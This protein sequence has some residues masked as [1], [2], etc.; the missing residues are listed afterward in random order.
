MAENLEA[1]PQCIFLFDMA[2]CRSH[3]FFRYLSTHPEVLPLWHPFLPAFLFGPERFTLRTKNSF[4]G[5]WIPPSEG[6]STYSDMTKIFLDVVKNT[7]EKGK[8]LV[9]NEHCQMVLKQDVTLS[10]IRGSWD[11]QIPRSNPTVIPDQIFATLRPIFII[12]NPV[13]SV[14]SSYISFSETSQIRTGDEDWTTIIDLRLPRMIFDYFKAN[15]GATPIVIDGDDIVWRTSEVGKKLCQELK[16]EYGGLSDVWEPVPEDQRSPWSVIRHFLQTIDA[17][18]GI[19]RPSQNRP[20]DDIEIARS[21]WAERF[22]AEVAEA[23]VKDVERNRPHYEY[24]KQF[25]I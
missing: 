20:N 2:R 6:G 15:S 11:G 1:T 25:R 23:L 10:I 24:L 3:L 21:R 7:G 5:E 22:G 4:E 19:E 17:S 18:T 8:I 13:F 14:P 12:R 16:L 9:A